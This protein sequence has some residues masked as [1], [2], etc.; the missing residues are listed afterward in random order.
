M[1]HDRCD[2]LEQERFSSKVHKLVSYDMQW[3]WED[4]NTKKKGCR[5]IISM[6]WHHMIGRQ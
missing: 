4:E 1:I 6:L 2:Y 3:K 5:D